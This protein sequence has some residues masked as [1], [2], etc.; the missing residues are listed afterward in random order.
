ML[1]I[2]KHIRSI[3][4]SRP[5]AGRLR[6]PIIHPSSRFGTETNR[7]SSLVLVSALTLLT[8]AI[9]GYHPYS[10]DGGLYIAGIKR[11][12]HPELYAASA[13][14]V[15]A[16]LHF[17]FFAPTVAALVR[18]SHLSLPYVLLLIHFGSLWATLFAFWLI[19]ERTLFTRHARLGAVF[20][21]A[22]CLTLPVAGTSL[23]LMDPYVTARS[24]SLPCTLFA[25]A[26]TFILMRGP[27]R[28]RGGLLTGASLLLAAVMHPLMAG[29]AFGATLLLAAL[30]S[31]RRGVR[32][33]GTLALCLAAISAA[34][35]VQLTAQPESAAYLPIALS[36]YYWFLSRWQ[37]YELVGLA[38]P[39]AI[40]TSYAL[41]KGPARPFARMAV[42]AGSTGIL[43]A[44]LFAHV[45]AR[46]HLV[47]RLQPLRS[48]QPI[49]IAMILVLGGLL[50]EHVLRGHLWRWA[51]A[52]VLLGGIF[53]SVQR[54]TYPA[55]AHIEWPGA[56]PSNLYEQAF[57]WISQ[58]T[59][60]DALFALDPH[61]IF[62]P[63]E[64]AQGFRALAER[65]VLPDYS[66][67]G[68]EAANFPFL[69]DAWT[70]AQSA[71]AGLNQRT[72]GERLAALRPLNVTWIVLQ[73]DAKTGFDC[74]F[75]NAAVAVCRLP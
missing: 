54:A 11:L 55:S 34:A 61:Y 13:A 60:V 53:F 69:T 51:A 37:W 45:G 56:T 70:A 17:F 6:T 33:W 23:I 49:Y 72:D 38:A 39:L 19:A 3:V 22:L 66:K 40:L 71:Q 57:I 75:R 9:H 32:R 15:E 4:P 30:L 36:R 43:I 1:S 63:G 29:Y 14:F 16:P 59:P 26:G 20:L 50:G 62:A 52:A 47:A 74:P 21:F 25:L 5:Y 41:R 68:G 42:A 27:D 31:S 7:V 73:Q 58:N 48:F 24:V 10:E 2:R 65:S 46:T 67:D 28:W 44:L 64:D 8:F 18:V 35:I 12:L